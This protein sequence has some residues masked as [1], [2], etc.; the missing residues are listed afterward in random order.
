[1]I[2]TTINIIH[3]FSYYAHYDAIIYIMRIISLTYGYV[4]IMRS[5]RVAASC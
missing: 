3:D 4:Y 5:P 2:C 1:M